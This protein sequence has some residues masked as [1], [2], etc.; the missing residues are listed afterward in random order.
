M[1]IYAILLL[2]FSGLNLFGQ[3]VNGIVIDEETGEPV[4]F[5]NVWIKGTQTG[6]L[7]DVDG[8]FTLSVKEGDT[9][10]V[11]S[12]SY[13][14][15]ETP[16]EGTGLLELT[17][18]LTPSA[19][20]ISE[21]TVKPDVELAQLIFERIQENK[22]A[23][24]KEVNSVSDY[25]SL[26]NTTVFM[27]IDTQSRFNILSGDIRE[28][29]VESGN[30]QIRFTPIY[31]SEKAS[32]NDEVLDERKESVFPRVIP[33]IESYVLKNS[34]VEVDFYREQ[35]FVLD[36]GFISPLSGSAMLFYDFS[37]NDSIVVDDQLY[38]NLSFI[39]K[40]RYNPLF[41][42]NMTIE[43]GS[44]ALVDI[45]AHVSHQANI[46][47][48]NGFSA[49]ASYKRLPDGRMF[50]DQQET[51][52]NMSLLVNR[53]TLEQYTSERV[54]VVSGGNWLINK[55]TQ[56]SKSE[57]LEGVS[58]RD[59]GRQPEF[60]SRQMDEENFVRI[61]QIREMRMVKIIDAIGGVALT[62]F[63]NVGKF[64]VGPAFD[65]YSSNLIEGHRLSIPLRTSEQ[66][67]EQF[68]VGGFLAYGTKS[69]EFKFGANVAW[70]PFETDRFLFRF[71]YANDYRLLSNEKFL[72]FVKN[73]PNNRGTGNFFALATQRERNP[74]LK[75][76]EN[77]DFRIEYNA[78]NDLYLEISPYYHSTT[79]TPFVRFVKQDFDYENYRNYGAL[80]NFRIP[81]GQ[82]YDK[83]FFDRIYYVSPEPVINLSVDIGQ[84]H[85][86]GEGGQGLY[87]H[88]H[89]SIQGRINMGQVF[90]NYIFDAG[91]LMGNAPY[92]LL[93]QP[94]GSM[95]LGFSRDRYNLLH[96]ATFAH[97]AYT[98]TH[99]HVN[100]G[101]ILLNRIPLIRDLKLREIVSLK[102]HYGTL[103][104]DYEGVFDLPEFF[105]RDFSGP[106]AE[107]GF[108]VTNIFK[109]LRVE[110]VRQ[111]G[112]TYSDRDYIDKNGIRIRA[113]MSF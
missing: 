64:D 74:Y 94:V 66:L 107:I 72:R 78:P 63:F 68:S 49:S 35:I 109:V 101:G 29:T 8:T 45:E 19:V 44:Y 84:V 89:G 113:E 33:F 88:F 41:T 111:L 57:R 92:D 22:R 42:G 86:P 112:N 65:I 36:R 23:N 96:H 13:R 67:S 18:R 3:E 20:Q 108:G 91:Y 99:L 17:I 32:R 69:K 83:F 53:D 30:E 47:F 11:S 102:T 70:Q 105:S 93:N 27:A 12:V 7:S 52:L 98:N 90:M 110:Y 58:V 76:V 104:N 6:T 54:D 40:N 4:P 31:I 81:F 79:A 39:P 103:N 82:H 97:N 21:V 100:G 56:F 1:R 73:N 62:G 80:L 15:R 2:L 16:V 61:D 50:F 77:F 87:T 71:S 25:Q 14:P 37:F 95:S 51:R 60:S 43:A 24:A 34:M 55:H 48:V 106:Y 5:A 85:L 10:V 38:L 28:V 75:E 26:G 46:N 9:I 59:W